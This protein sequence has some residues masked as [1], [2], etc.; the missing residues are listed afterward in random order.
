[1]VSSS[2]ELILNVLERVPS[3]LVRES[4]DGTVSS[5]KLLVYGVNGM[6]SPRTDSSDVVLA[7][8]VSCSCETRLSGQ[9]DV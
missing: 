7:S 2:D 1:M 9:Q 5:D 3:D 8:G 4:S 6:S